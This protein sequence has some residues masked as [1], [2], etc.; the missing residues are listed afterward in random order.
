MF[1]E[2]RWSLEHAYKGIGLAYG[3]SG[4]ESDLENSAEFALRYWAVF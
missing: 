4:M 3:V 2:T 1:Q